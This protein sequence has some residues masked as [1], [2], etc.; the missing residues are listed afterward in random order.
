M[1]SK[2][3]TGYLSVGLPSQ[4]RRNCSSSLSLAG[5]V[6]KPRAMP[7]HLIELGQAE[8]RRQRIDLIGTNRCFDVKRTASISA[9]GVYEGWKNMIDVRVTQSPKIPSLS[10]TSRFPS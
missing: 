6:P 8:A 10:S 5:L 9:D 2:V 3:V 1:K 4:V 7:R